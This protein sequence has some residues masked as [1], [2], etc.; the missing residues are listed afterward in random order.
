MSPPTDDLKKALSQTLDHHVKVE[1]ELKSSRHQV[2]AVEE[3]QRHLDD[4]HHALE[5]DINAIRY[6]LERLRVEREGW[7]VKADT[8]IEQ[9][10]E[11]TFTLDQVLKT[12]P[13]EACP[14]EWQTKLEQTINRIDRLGPINLVAI[15]E[16]T[17]CLKEKSI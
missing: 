10:S 1:S 7:K 5:Q 12:L 3:K 6:Q 13:D 16:Y 15:D 2:E 14:H 11:T 9:L 8:L 17:T 4:K